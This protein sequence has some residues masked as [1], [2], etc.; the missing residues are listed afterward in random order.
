MKPNN[1]TKIVSA[2]QFRSCTIIPC[3]PSCCFEKSVRRGGLL[4]HGEIDHG[5]EHG[6]DDHPRQLKPVEKWHADEGWLRLVV[7][8]RPQ[9]HGKLDDK[10]QIPPAPA[11]AFFFCAVHSEFPPP[12]KAPSEPLRASL[13]VA[14]IFLLGRRNPWPR[15]A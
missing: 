7:E 8:G 1:N 2:T 9:G 11:A 5:R 3:V 6:A 10:Q 15:S 13:R 14:L 12:P 4:F